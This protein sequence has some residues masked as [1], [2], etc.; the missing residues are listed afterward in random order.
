MGPRLI[1]LNGPAGVGKSTLARRYAEEHPGTLLCD[2]D[3]LRTW[4]GGWLDHPDAA[5]R[6]RA[7]ALAMIAAYLRTGHDVVLPQLVAR[8]DQLARFARAAAE[9]GG[10]HVHVM[11]TI[12][13]QAAVRRF[14]TRAA[15]SDD[16][17]TAF[18][19]AECDHHGGDEALRE[20]AARLG[21]MGGVRVPSTDLD[22]TYAALLRVLEA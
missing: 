6:A 21:T 18:V 7:T 12:D 19:T 4:I 8:E 11:L 2:A 9:G 20:W 16:E 3:V 5:E 15:E 22:T 13:P 17:W 10:A 1:H 14:R